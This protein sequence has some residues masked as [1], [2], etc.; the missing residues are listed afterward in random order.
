MTLCWAGQLSW[1]SPCLH[2]RTAQRLQQ[3]LEVEASLEN[4]WMGGWIHIMYMSF[5]S[6]FYS[7]WMLLNEWWMLAASS[8]YFYFECS[9]RCWEFY[10]KR[11]IK[12]NHWVIEAF[13]T[14][15]P[16]LFKINQSNKSPLKLS[17][18]SAL[19]LVLLTAL[20]ATCTKFPPTELVHQLF[21]CGA[22][23]FY[24]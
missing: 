2:P 5:L 10:L 19:V 23:I 13:I 9:V 21:S 3:N 7:E 24:L 8:L 20:P 16:C 18:K 11:W 22:V 4:E 17:G 14:S 6:W 15:W 1:S 12:K